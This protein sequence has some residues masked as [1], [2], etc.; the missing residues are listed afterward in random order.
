MFLFYLYSIILFG[1]VQQ[2]N[3]S[4]CGCLPL[5][6]PSEFYRYNAKYEREFTKY[7]EH[8][9]IFSSS[10]VRSWQK[11]YKRSTA[12][13]F[14]FSNRLKNTPEDSIYTI[15]G[16][17]YEAKMNKN[18]CDL[19]LEIGTENPSA[20]RAVAEITKDNCLLQE[21]IIRELQAKGLVIGKQNTKGVKC[22]LKGMGFY[23]GKHPL[24]SDKKHERGSAWEIH[25]VISI[26]LE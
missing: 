17:I 7:S 18:D 25:P 26:E 13:I 1:L 2:P 20:L 14:D 5:K 4:A 22:T 12:T 11:T 24:K 3:D 10:T 6:S 23:D 19:H 16:Y 9:G 8:E 21:Q 15:A